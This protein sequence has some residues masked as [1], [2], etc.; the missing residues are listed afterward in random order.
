MYKC[1]YARNWG[2][3]SCSK[4]FR[5]PGN[6]ETP[7]HGTEP[8]LKLSAQELFGSSLRKGP[9]IQQPQSCVA[10][11]IHIEL[12]VSPLCCIIVGSQARGP[13]PKCRDIAA[14]AS[15]SWFGGVPLAVWTVKCRQYSYTINYFSKEKCSEN[16]HLLL[17]LGRYNSSHTP[18]PS[19][20]RGRVEHRREHAEVSC[21]LVP[22]RRYI[23][24]AR[25]TSISSRNKGQMMAA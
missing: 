24:E 2:S 9:A 13:N 1:I 14:L 5:I 25:K 3:S 11:K 10:S 21:V 7:C 20:P 19:R 23:C 8:S 18:I 15:A 17:L 12:W 22:Q 4:R 6:M 16:T